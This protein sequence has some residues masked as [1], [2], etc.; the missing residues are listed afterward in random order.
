MS[1]VSIHYFCQS[2]SMNMIK[3]LYLIK[4]EVLFSQGEVKNQLTE[5]SAQGTQ[6]SQQIIFHGQSSKPYKRPCNPLLECSW[7]DKSAVLEQDLKLHQ[8][9]VFDHVFTIK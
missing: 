6:L 1:F 9:K 5:R 4:F 7:C 8:V 3:Y 2:L